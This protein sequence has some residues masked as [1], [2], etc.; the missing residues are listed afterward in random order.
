[1]WPTTHPF[2]GYLLY[3]GYARL[4]GGAPPRDGP[5]VAVV[6]GALLP[7]LIDKPLWL[8]VPGL[9]GR[10]IGHSLLFAGPLCALVAL[11]SRRSGRPAVGVLVSPRTRARRAPLVG[12][13]F[14]VGYASHLLGDAL[15]ALGAGT[16][17]EL[18]YL[19]WP[20]T[21]MPPY[22]GQKHLATVADVDVTTLWVEA[23]LVVAT[24]GLWLR[25][26]KP[27]LGRE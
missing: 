12:V 14:A 26:G 1:M 23:A 19:L 21:P 15:Y 3:S 10:T 25:D 11:D 27:G 24:V 5:T 13:A 6:I 2:F 22:E 4:A 8:A 18:G 17:H 20:I 9:G 7:D 16:Y